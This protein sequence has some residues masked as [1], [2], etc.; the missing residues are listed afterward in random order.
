MD[1]DEDFED[2]KNEYRD[3]LFEGVDVAL[4]HAS[5]IVDN[6]VAE[7][8]P[9]K[10]KI[11]PIFQQ[12]AFFD[13]IDTDDLH[14]IASKT[15]QPAKK[16]RKMNPKNSIQGLVYFKCHEFLVYIVLN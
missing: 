6:L 15:V 2:E 16:R 3:K 5:Q 1:L 8:S 14:Q 10:M 13:A 9:E 12:Q 11:N 4:L 7:T